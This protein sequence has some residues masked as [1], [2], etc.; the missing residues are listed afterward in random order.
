[1]RKKFNKRYKKTRDKREFR[2]EKNQGLGDLI[3]DFFFF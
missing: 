3:N 2:N 1:M